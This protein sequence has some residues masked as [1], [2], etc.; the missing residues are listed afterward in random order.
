MKRDEAAPLMEA[1]TM[2]DVATAL[3]VVMAGHGREMDAGRIKTVAMLILDQGWKRAELEQASR[4]LASDPELRRDLRFGD[5]LGS[6]HFEGVRQADEKTVGEGDDKR[7]IVTKSGFALRVARARLYDYAEAMG[8]W[9][10]A[11]E[12]G[13]FGTDGGRYPDAMFEAVKVEGQERVMWRFA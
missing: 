10:A 7:V 5:T 3:Q 13:P 12:P 8:L 2:A 6:S 9:R 11:G 4:V 1:A